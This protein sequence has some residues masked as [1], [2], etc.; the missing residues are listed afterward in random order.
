[1]THALVVDHVNDQDV[2]FVCSKCGQPIRFNKPGIGQPCAIDNGDGTW[3]APDNHDQ[4]MS[5]CPE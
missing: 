2:H 5:P 1:M 3:S 4:W